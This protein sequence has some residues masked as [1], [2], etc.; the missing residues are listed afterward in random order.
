MS[1]RSIPPLIA[2]RHAPH[3]LRAAALASRTRRDTAKHRSFVISA[4]HR[5]AFIV[6]TAAYFLSLLASYLFYIA[7]RYSYYGLISDFSVEKTVLSGL[8]VLGIATIHPVR[9][10]RLASVLSS[11]AF[12][13]GFV[14]LS[15][16]FGAANGDTFFYINSALAFLLFLGLANAPYLHM[17]ALYVPSKAIEIALWAIV[18][19]DFILLIAL[20]G[21]SIFSLDPFTVYE[22]RPVA[23]SMFSGFFLPYLVPWAGNVALPILMAISL[24]R[25]MYFRSAAILMLA[26]GLYGFTT[27]K[28]IAVT[29]LLV[30]LLYVF[31]RRK[32][33]MLLA[34]PSG[35]AVV[36]VLGISEAVTFGTQTI[37]G[38]LIRRALFVPA[39]LAFAY[40]AVFSQAG[41][42]Y[43]T[44]SSLPIFG[45]YPF[46]EP[47]TMM[48][49]R[50][51]FGH[52]FANAN[53]G[54]FG[55]GYMQFGIVGIYMWLGIVGLLVNI[56]G[57][58][59]RRLPIWLSVPV[60]AVPILGFFTNADLPTGLVTHGFG[61]L[62]VVFYALSGSEL[63]NVHWKRDRRIGSVRN[64]GT[65]RE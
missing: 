43:M 31:S 55:A 64:Y 13:V 59:A 63:T 16:F 40:Y 61:L 65:R 3:F 27:H 50:F 33:P 9:R 22:R 38:F 19:Y 49:S 15:V 37:N 5:I 8:V 23:S 56:M 35:G 57:G 46:P 34:F 1:E 10:G 44:A 20:G 6:A 45:E 47:P 18:V 51:V 14:P 41:F 42:V 48:V 32:V 58:F 2:S 7:P 52:P 60:T 54:L 39:M 28:T 17:P 53:N 36:T 62:I 26:V 4:L 12:F 30:V 29:T 11:L 21:L 24:H 25:R